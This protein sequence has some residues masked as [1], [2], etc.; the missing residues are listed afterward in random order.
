MAIDKNNIEKYIFDPNNPRQC[1]SYNLLLWIAKREHYT[2]ISPEFLFYFFREQIVNRDFD[3][4]IWDKPEDYNKLDVFQKL[5][6]Y[7]LILKWN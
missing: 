4:A 1:K 6:L 7:K 5:R 2:F 3:E